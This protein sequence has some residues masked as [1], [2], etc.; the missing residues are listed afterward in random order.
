MRRQGWLDVWHFRIDRRANPRKAAGT[1]LLNERDQLLAD[2]AAKVPGERC[3]SGAG[4]RADFERLFLRI[5]H[6]KNV[7]L[8]V[9]ETG[10]VPSPV[11]IRGGSVIQFFMSSTFPGRV[12]EMATT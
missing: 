4:E 8:A 1:L 6:L 7:D 3:I 2:L 5:S 9:P 10:D 12:S 11:E